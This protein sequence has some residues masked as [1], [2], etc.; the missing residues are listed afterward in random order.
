MDSRGIHPLVISM[1]FC[2]GVDHVMIDIIAAMLNRTD[3]DH[4]IRE[5]VGAGAISILV[6]YICGN[7]NHHS[8]HKAMTS[9]LETIANASDEF[10]EDLIRSN[11][12]NDLCA[13]LE[14][15]YSQI[16]GSC[17]CLMYLIG[18]CDGSNSSQLVRCLVL[19]KALRFLVRAMIREEFSEG[20]EKDEVIQDSALKIL[21]VVLCEESMFVSMLKELAEAGIIANAILLVKQPRYVDSA[22]RILCLTLET[23]KQEH[24]HTVVKD[25]DISELINFVLGCNGSYMDNDNALDALSYISQFS[26]KYRDA[27]LHSGLLRY[28]SDGFKRG[29]RYYLFFLYSM[30]TAG[31]NKQLADEV[32]KLDLIQ[33]LL[34]SAAFHCSHD[35]EG[36]CAQAYSVGV[37]AITLREKL[38]ICS[39]IDE[40]VKTSIISQLISF[41]CNS[42]FREDDN[43]ASIII[44]TL[45]IEKE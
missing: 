39:L 24:A 9:S 25:D 32:V 15:K 31:Q 7:S 37:L 11:I 30:G 36:K 13:G 14:G 8:A 6:Q 28:V 45:T 29:K 34:S 2:A 1:S 3:N 16:Q 41:L 21:S 17:L 40:T 5:V 23:L 26:V 38:K 20:E 43:C 27:I 19:Y 22:L 10:H 44:K 12:L 4:I 18:Y 33:P 42:K 35:M